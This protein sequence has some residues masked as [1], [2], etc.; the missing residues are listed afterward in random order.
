MKRKRKKT[1]SESNISL[2]KKSKDDSNLYFDDEN[3]ISFDLF[4]PQDLRSILKILQNKILN[5]NTVPNYEKTPSQKKPNDSILEEPN[6]TPVKKSL[7]GT[8]PYRNS[9]KK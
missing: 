9:E 4:I 5:L 8:M 7:D 6:R 2:N 3:I 1:L